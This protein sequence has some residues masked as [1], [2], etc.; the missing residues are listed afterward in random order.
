MSGRSTDEPFRRTAQRHP[1]GRHDD[2][3]ARAGRDRGRPGGVGGD[4]RQGRRA[5]ASTRRP[6]RD[7]LAELPAGDVAAGATVVDALVATGLVD[8]RNAARRVLGEGGVSVNNVKVTDADAVL[9]PE[10][11]LHGYAV[12][13]A[14]RPQGPGRRTARRRR[15]DGRV[16]LST[17]RALDGRQRAPARSRE[18]EIRSI[19]RSGRNVG[20][21]FCSVSPRGRNGHPPPRDG[22]SRGLT[23]T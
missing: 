5:C 3:R 1:G 2:A 7:A 12:A 8:S 13:A 20:L 11:F 15:T 19:W 18:H 22:R 6:W 10:D 23:P 9:R 16:D 17:A 14:S 21:W 4:L